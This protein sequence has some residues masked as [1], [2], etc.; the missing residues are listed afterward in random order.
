WGAVD[1]VAAERGGACRYALE[2]VDIK[3]QLAKIVDRG[4]NIKVPKKLHK[5]I[6]LPAGISRSLRV[7][8]VKLSLNVKPT[9]VLMSPERVWYG[10]DLR[11]EDTSATSAGTG[12]RPRPVRNADAPRAP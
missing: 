10:A 1:E 7:Q 9:G 11:I 12:E 5:P 4:F 8:G 3:K 2:K 6:R